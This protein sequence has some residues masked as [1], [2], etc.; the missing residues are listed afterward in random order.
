MQAASVIIPCHNNQ[1]TLFWILRAV[2]ASQCPGLEV[3]CVDDESTEDIGATARVFGAR[4][5]RL[6]DGQPGRR[7]M[8]RNRGH[9][10]AQGRV[11]FYLDGDVI[12][13]PRLVAFAIRLH[14]KIP[15]IVVKYPVYSIPE[16]IHR[17]SI[18]SLAPSMI[19]HDLSRLGPLAAKHICA[20]TARLPKR[21]RGA[22]TA[23]WFACASHCMSVERQ[24]V[25]AAG[26][27]DEEF[28]GWG[29]EDLELA[30]RLRQAGLAFVYPHRKYGAGY[31]LDHSLHW[32]SRLNT[33]D[34]NVRYFRDK[35]P[36]SWNVRRKL[37][38]SFLQ[39]NGLPQISAV[40][41][42]DTN[43]QGVQPQ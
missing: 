42:D 8:A 4:Y 10:A 18:D 30:Y 2:G 39:E 23:M 14:A 43:A 9:Q 20:Y 6:P 25:E 27:W 24:D 41:D 13:E 12:P 31:H 35:F 1:H 3:I 16:R 38:R 21:L 34:R 36:G 26:G 11:T 29:E 15:R 40:L 37:L 19:S 7:A 22:R 17:E 32:C 33:L 28:V 5:I